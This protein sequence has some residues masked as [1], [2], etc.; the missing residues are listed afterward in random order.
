MGS[1]RSL[2][3][4][5]TL[6]QRPEA[7]TVALD[8]LRATY[9][10]DLLGIIHTDPLH[11]GIATALRQLETVLAQDYPELAVRRHCVTYPNN[12]PLLD[13]LDGRS[14]EAYY[15]S[16]VEILRHY[17]GLGAMLHLLV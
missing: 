13:I 14:A 17:R 4:L 12:L 7:I 2:I 8:M 6:G 15:H 11:S 10:Y 1:A 5:A 9:P 16:V 3:L